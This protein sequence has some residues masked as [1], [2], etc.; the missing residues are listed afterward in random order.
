MKKLVALFAVLMLLQLALADEVTYNGSS[1]EYNDT[2]ITTDDLPDNN[3]TDANDTN[4]S[5][6][7]DIQLPSLPDVNMSELGEKFKNA[8]KTGI[9]PV[10]QIGNFLADA[11][12]FLILIIG[13]ALIVLSGFGKII[14]IILIILALIRLLWVLFL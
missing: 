3:D 1:L 5:G 12:P 14:G 13:I 11:S 8:T 7:L 6:G 2:N 4:N 10:D 9:E